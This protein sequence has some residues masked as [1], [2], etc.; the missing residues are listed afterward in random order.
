VGAHVGRCQK[1]A[2]TPME[3]DQP[4][5]PEQPQQ[6][7]EPQQPQQE[8]E[9]SVWEQ[10][11]A[12]QQAKEAAWQRRL[13]TEDLEFR[14]VFVEITRLGKLY[15]WT[16]VHWRR[17]AFEH[18]N[19]RWR[20]RQGLLRSNPFTEEMVRMYC[21]VEDWDPYGDQVTGSDRRGYQGPYGAAP[22]LVSLCS[23]LG[24]Q[25]SLD[26]RTRVPRQT[27]IDKAERLNALCQ[28]LEIEL[29]LNERRM[30]REEGYRR[31]GTDPR[32]DVHRLVRRIQGVMREFCGISKFA[33]PAGD[34]KRT[35]FAVHVAP[36]T[37]AY[38]LS[39]YHGRMCA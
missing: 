23:E 5:E 39:R 20:S 19:R 8:P 32:H 11:V 24:L 14:D 38:V 36:D 21:E 16:D 6:Q 35:C 17:L 1:C 37:L 7:T 31:R 33:V 26:T 27:L 29:Y 34:R 30:R 13:D 15:K 10:F 4:Q 2:Q 18:F 28:D 22:V 3:P 9:L 12:M 25:H